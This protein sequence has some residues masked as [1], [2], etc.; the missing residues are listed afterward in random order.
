MR[1]W[2]AGGGTGG[3]LYPALAIARALTEVRPDLRPLFIGARR[4]IENRVLPESGFEHLLLD[5]HPLYRSAFW[6]NRRTL[7]GAVS[8]WRHL[9]HRHRTE[10]PSAVVATGGYG[11]ALALLFAVVHRIPIVLQEQNSFPGLTTRIFSR[12]AR[13]VY[14]GFPEAAHYL[15]KPG[16]QVSKDLGNPIEPPPAVTQ[17][18]RAQARAKWNVR[19]DDPLLLIFGGSQGARAINETVAEWIRGGRHGS[20]EILWST[21]SAAYE[22]FAPLENERV[23]VRSFISPMADA[24]AA[25][26]AAVARA[27]AMSTAELCSW[28]IPQILVPL[29][30]AAADHQTANARALEKAGVAIVIPQSELTVERLDSAVRTMLGDR[31]RF[32]AMSAAALARARPRAAAAIALD[33]AATLGA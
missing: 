8:G 21:G 3:H 32:D 28:G 10:R 20:L 25:A 30:T 27:G 12:F 19:T 13:R 23:R 6:N 18:L 29:P 14:L 22:K 15:P 2:F 9:R 24:Y 7:A 33:I 1:V 4:G 5:L 31:R 17:P 26:D 16:R 11:G